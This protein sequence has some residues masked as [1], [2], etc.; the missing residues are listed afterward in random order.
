MEANVAGK[1]T[2]QSLLMWRLSDVADVA[3][4]C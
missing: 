2:W 1:M 4:E 3:P